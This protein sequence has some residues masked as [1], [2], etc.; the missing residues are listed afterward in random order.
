MNPLKRPDCSTLLKDEWFSFEKD[1]SLLKSKEILIQLSKFKAKNT[2]S[3]A[4]LT[5]IV[6]NIAHK[7][8]DEE[9]LK[10]FRYLDKDGDGLLSEEELIYGFKSIFPQKKEET[11]KVDVARIISELDTNNSGT[12][13]FSEY[14]IGVMDR[15]TILSKQSVRTAFKMFDKDDDGEITKKEFSEIMNGVAITDEIWTS[16]IVDCDTQHTGTVSLSL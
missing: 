8:A 3:L 9:T 10:L 5:F 13:D 14:L 6:A 16:L 7:D 4:V 12:I 1:V 2:F 15:N 11:I